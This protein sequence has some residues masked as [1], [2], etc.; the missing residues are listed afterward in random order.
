MCNLL[1]LLAI[2]CQ[3]LQQ[4]SNPVILPLFIAPFPPIYTCCVIP[5]APASAFGQL[6][7]S[8]EEQS[9]NKNRRSAASPPWQ[10]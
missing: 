3:Q 1:S 2:M 10:S 4:L 6:V 5:A 7:I 8:Y 9:P